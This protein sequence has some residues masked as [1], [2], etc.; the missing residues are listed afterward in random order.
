MARSVG[1][2]VGTEGKPRLGTLLVLKFDD[3]DGADR[4]L[5]VLQGLQERQM[6]TLEDAAVVAAP[7]LR[8]GKRLPRKPL[9]RKSNFEE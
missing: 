1:K 3:P 4:V 2:R 6:I 7:A 8:Y 9:M 5:L